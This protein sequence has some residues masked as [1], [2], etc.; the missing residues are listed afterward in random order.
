MKVKDNR[1]PVLLNFG[2]LEFVVS[3]EETKN[4]AVQGT[5]LQKFILWLPG[6]RR[7]MQYVLRVVK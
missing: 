3:F 4:P 6:P 1:D 2:R 5:L 7:Y